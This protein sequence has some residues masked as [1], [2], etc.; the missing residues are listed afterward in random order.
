MIKVKLLA[1]KH[2]VYNE[3][4]NFSPS[5]IKYSSQVTRNVIRHYTWIATLKR[6]TLS[7]ILKVIHMPRVIYLFQNKSNLIHS[8]RGIVILNKKPWVIDFEHVASCVGNDFYQINNSHYRKKIEKFFSSKYCK[9]ILPWSYA[10]KQTIF[11]YLD[12][13]KFKDKIEVIYPAMHKISSFKKEKSENIRILFVGHAFL[14]KGGLD[15]VEAF[16]ILNK[17]YDVKLTMITHLPKNFDKLKQIPNVNLISQLPRE[18]VFEYY[19]QADIFCLPSYV[20][21]F[22]F[23]LLEAKAFGLPIIASN[24]FA[25][26]EIIQNGKNGLTIKIPERIKNFP[27]TKNPKKDVA[28]YLNYIGDGKHNKLIKQLVD[29]FKILIENDNLRKKFVKQGKK[30]IER[31]KFSIKERNK[32][33]RRIYEEAISRK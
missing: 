2:A 19:K 1:G 17:K 14:A 4:I 28:A 27:F 26:P 33:L 21:S 6:K 23:V 25:M 5:N 8:C 20:D 9:K 16:K 13:S 30:E 11:H 22:G 31:G 15:L 24:F 12:T 29:K 18:K 10:A 32:K 3:L 7:F